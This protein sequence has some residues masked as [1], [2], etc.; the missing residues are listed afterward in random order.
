MDVRHSA[1]NQIFPFHFVVTV[2]LEWKK[3]KVV[4]QAE[5]V[6]AGWRGLPR[7]ICAQFG[8]GHS[9]HHQNHDTTR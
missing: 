5:Q 4:P 2:P 7:I 8:P 9:G 3:Q 1:G 6:M